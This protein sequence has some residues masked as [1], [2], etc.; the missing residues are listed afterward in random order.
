M[1]EPAVFDRVVTA[2]D[3]R[4]YEPL[5]HVPEAH[6]DAYADVLDRCR[7][8]RIAIRGR[9]PDVLG[10]TDANR[11]FAIEVKG[12]SNLLRGIGQALTYQQGAHVSYL[13][14]HGDAVRPHADLLRSKGIG[15]IGV[16]DDGATAWR[17]PPSAESTAEVTDVEGQLSLRL[18]GDEFGGDV[19][20]LSLAQP[21][22]Y[23]AP[24]VALDRDGPRARDE[25][26][27]AIADEYGFGAGGETV[28][29]AQTLGLVTAGSPHE[30][31]EQ[32][33]LAATV[34]RGYGVEDLDDL[35]LTKEDVGRRTVAEV[36]PPL[37]V[38][39]KNS[40]VRHPEF[41]LLLDALRKEG[42]R[43]HFLDLV[44]RLVREYPNVFLSAFCTTRGAARA[45][46]L[47]ERG[48][49]SRLYRDRGV[50]TDVIRTNVLFNFVQQLKHVGVL[51]PETRSHSGAIADYDPDAKPWIVVG[52]GDD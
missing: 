47:I 37:A 41:G 44:E 33:E 52:G 11:V 8:H 9:Y 2:L 38:L 16:D 14:G 18:R 20:T 43:V 30:L 13:A 10:F 51:A 50:W 21:L 6:A 46:E 49:T 4:N 32:G 27:D 40:F 25:I 29:S 36:H 35:R 22:N 45:R 7:R 31:T 19:T 24:V 28:A 3:E 23:F 17:S 15:V 5:V 48:E 34:L 26:V 12:S 1:D 39:L 42:P